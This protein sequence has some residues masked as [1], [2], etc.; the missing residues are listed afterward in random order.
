M[1]ERITLPPPIL[2]DAVESVL[3]EQDADTRVLLVHVAALEKPPIHVLP[4]IRAR[5]EDLVAWRVRMILEIGDEPQL[6]RM[7]SRDVTPVLQRKAAWPILP[8]QI[9]QLVV[10]DRWG[11]QMVREE[12]AELGPAR[13]GPR[14]EID[15]RQPSRRRAR[16]AR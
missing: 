13:L 3:L 16:P 14:S 6:Q 2:K 1:S 12:V 10:I 15:D 7:N 5:L 4:H 11:R 9:P 8:P